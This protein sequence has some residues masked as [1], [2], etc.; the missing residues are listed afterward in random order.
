VVALAAVG[1]V[2]VWVAF[3]AAALGGALFVFDAFGVDDAGDAS[4]LYLLVSCHVAEY[5]VP[6]AFAGAVYALAR[7]GWRGDAVAWGGWALAAGVGS[8]LHVALRT[9]GSLDA[10][11]TLVVGLGWPGV[12]K[13]GLS[14]AAVLVVEARRRREAVGAAGR[15][16]C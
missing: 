13:L 3:L 10:T 7:R 6:A 11:G 5:W 16:S 2:L 8:L 12:A 14:I 4:R 15:E 9:P 1:P